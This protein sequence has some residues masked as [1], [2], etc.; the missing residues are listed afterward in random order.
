MCK[1][2][3]RSLIVAASCVV[4]LLIYNKL[5]KF[6]SITGSMS[7]TPIAFT[8]PAV[9]HYKACAKTTS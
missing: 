6:L 9:F 7:C 8:L 1:N 3:T 2:L 5:D 4:S